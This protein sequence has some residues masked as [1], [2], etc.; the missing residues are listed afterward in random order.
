M[1]ASIPPCPNCA[2]T[3]RRS[4]DDDGLLCKCGLEITGE[5]F[6]ARRSRGQPLDVRDGTFRPIPQSTAGIR[7]GRKFSELMDGAWFADPTPPPTGLPDIAAHAIAYG[8]KL[9]LRHQSQEFLGQSLVVPRPNGDRI[10]LERDPVYGLC[11]PHEI[12]ECVERMVDLIAEGGPGDWWSLAGAVHVVMD[13][14]LVRWDAF[15]GEPHL[16][17]RSLGAVDRDSNK[18]TP[19]KFPG[20][21]YEPIAISSEAFKQAQ[22]ASAGLIESVRKS[23]DDYIA[24][25]Y[26]RIATELLKLQ[27]RPRVPVRQEGEFMREYL[28]EWKPQVPGSRIAAVEDLARK[29]CITRKEA[30]RLLEQPEISIETGVGTIKITADPT[31]KIDE[32]RIVSG[33]AVKEPPAEP[34]TKIRPHTLAAVHPHISPDLRRER[35]VP[36]WIKSTRTLPDG[37]FEHSCSETPVDPLDVEY[38]DLSLRYLLRCDE[39]NRRENETSTFSPAQRA[40]I[41]AHWSAELRAKVAASKERERSAVTYCEVDADD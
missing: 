11:R 17:L 23:A 24:K 21:K 10:Q 4:Y 31:L 28:G 39:L 12:L 8:A 25:H 37:T 26:K 36:V 40:A 18:P 32:M 20:Q 41:S 33:A 30:K 22:S 2:G 14:G 1:I 29:G 38:D 5:T 13:D 15:G 9:G 34:T 16:R 19:K 27:T 7:V 3:F 35:G 6:T